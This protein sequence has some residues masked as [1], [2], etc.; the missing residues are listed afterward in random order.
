MIRE[1]ILQ[2]IGEQAPTGGKVPRG[3]KKILLD[4][5]PTWRLVLGVSVQGEWLD[6]GLCTLRGE[7]VEHHALMIDPSTTFQKLVQRSGSL[8]RPQA[9]KMT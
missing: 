5:N 8:P 9:Y 3:R 6:V 4:Y 2:E 1:G 7:T